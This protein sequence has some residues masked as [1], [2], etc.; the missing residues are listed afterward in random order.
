[1]SPLDKAEPA[2]V[3]IL[4]MMS[5]SIA[6]AKACALI[7]SWVKQGH[8]VQVACTP[9]VAEFIGHATLEG[10]SGRPV[11]DSAFT[12]GQVMDHIHVARWADV[13][14]AA[15]ATSN[16][17]NKFAAGIADDVVTSLWQAAYG[18]GKPMFIVPA[19]NTHM[20]NYPATQASIQT[21]GGWGIHVLATADGDLACGEF[22]AGRMLEPEAIMAA[23]AP[24]FPGR[25]VR[26]KHILITAGGTREPIDAVRYIGNHSTGR[27]ASA[28]ADSLISRGHL[29][30]FL[31]AE[32]AMRPSL[33]CQIHPFSSYQD[34]ST[35][36]QR[37]LGQQHFDWVIHAAAV[38]DFSVDRI[39]QPGKDGNAKEKLSSEKLSS[40]DPLTLHLKPNAKLLQQLRH[41]SANTAV[42]IIGFKLT[43]TS[44]QASRVK[45]VKDLFDNAGVDAV[46]HNDLE[47]IRCGSHRYTLYSSPAAALDCANSTEL[48]AGIEQ[49]LEELT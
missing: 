34:L 6:C 9:S 5:G 43:S 29:V 25:T 38:S 10:F 11:L 13:V 46:V 30:S 21:L 27:T 18:S 7:S 42:R 32:N 28:L 23:I 12:P 33:P 14:V 15:P 45:A 3:N 19:M 44:D 35:E 41:W 22:G 47:E 17:I 36:L 2:R 39:E 37:T 40:A 20:W 49:L 1:M 16:L 26:P 4:L 8:Q 31:V 24:H 48:N